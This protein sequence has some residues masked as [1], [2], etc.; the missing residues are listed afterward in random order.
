MKNKKII[1]TFACAVILISGC[2]SKDLKRYSANLT[3]NSG[4]NPFALGLAAISYAAGTA[5]ETVENEEAKEKES[6][7]RPRQSHYLDNKIID[8]SEI[9]VDR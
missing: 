5:A 9:K 4:G 3:A 2:A 7:I 8:S 1:F 6:E